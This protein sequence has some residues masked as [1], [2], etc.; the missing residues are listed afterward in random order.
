MNDLIEKQDWTQPEIVDLDIN[1]TAT[2]D[3]HPI[4][5]ASSAGP[6]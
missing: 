5:I 1:K 3:I 2:G 6:S 4:E